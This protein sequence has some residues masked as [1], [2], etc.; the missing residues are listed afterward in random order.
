M[1]MFILHYSPIFQLRQYKPS[2]MRQHYILIKPWQ[3][4]HMVSM[5]HDYVYFTLFPNIS[6]K[7]VQT[8][9]DASTLHS[10][11]PLA[12]ETQMVSM[13]H[14]LV[15]FLH[16]SPIFQ[17]KTVQTKFDASTLHSNQPLAAETQM[18]SMSHD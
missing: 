3:L 12:A 17:F 4:R 13:S 16:Y 11:Q 1:I 6:A 9:F 14:D 8:K 7:T 15:Y 10:N 18:V 2:L 5:S